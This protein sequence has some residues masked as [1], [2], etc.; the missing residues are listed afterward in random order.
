MHDARHTGGH[1]HMLAAYFP[2]KQ[3]VSMQYMLPLYADVLSI[4]YLC[5]CET[6]IERSIYK[7]YLG[8]RFN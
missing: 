2:S 1:G 4:G 8:P 3:N 5:V 7:K 6:N